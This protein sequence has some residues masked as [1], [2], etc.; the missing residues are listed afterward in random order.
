MTSDQLRGVLRSLDTRRGD[1]PTTWQ[2]IDRAVSLRRRAWWRR[3]WVAGFPAAVVV[4]VVSV[5]GREVAPAPS[6]VPHDNAVTA[7]QP[8][9]AAIAAEPAPAASEQLCAPARNSHVRVPAPR[10]TA[11]ELY[12][13][14]EAALRS[15]DDTRARALL[16]RLLGEF[17][18]D[19]LV[20]P[21]RYD[22]AL[23][24][25]RAGDRDA[26]RAYATQLSL[27]ARDATLRAAAER[28]R[29]RL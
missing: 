2:R 28:L 8:P 25:A 16:A 12:A 24:L 15:H 13:R 14:A 23:I 7:Q 20:D 21:A 29:A 1:P 4:I 3:W 5:R 26:A 17:P 11:A 18:A 27:G 10:L 6:S 9:P 22:L 19:A